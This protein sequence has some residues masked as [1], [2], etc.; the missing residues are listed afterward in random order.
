MTV[1]ETAPT[2]REELNTELKS[3]LQRAHENDA[4]V[5]EAGNV[6]TEMD[7]RIGTLLL[8]RSRETERENDSR[9]CCGVSC[10]YCILKCCEHCE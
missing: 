6:G 2:T 9:F 7:I 3:L 5:E 4:G 1:D 8:R 10:T